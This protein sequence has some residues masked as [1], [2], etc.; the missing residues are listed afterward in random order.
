MK[1]SKNDIEEKFEATL[2]KLIE[3]FCLEKVVEVTTESKDGELVT[4]SVLYKSIGVEGRFDLFYIKQIDQN[5]LTKKQLIFS[6]YIERENNQPNISPYIE[7]LE[8][9]WLLKMED[10]GYMLSINANYANCKLNLS[11]EEKQKLRDSISVNGY[12]RE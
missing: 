6:K 1:H 8:E 7:N 11:E 10:N 9:N 4:E 12:F 5:K 3:N 2:K